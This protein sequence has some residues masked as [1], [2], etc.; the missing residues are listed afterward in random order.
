MGY[1]PPMPP[2]GYPPPM[3]WG[4]PP[5]M[6]YPPMVN[7]R[8]PEHGYRSQSRSRSRSGG[9]KGRG[10]PRGG[11]QRSRERGRGKSG[12]F[13]AFHAQNVPKGVDN[14]ARAATNASDGPKTTAML[15]NIPNKYMQSALLE[16]IDAEGFSGQYDFLYLPMD[17]HNKTNVGYA[18]VNFIQSSDLDRF[19]SQF[20][21]R[22]F[23]KYPS[24]KI[25]M[26]SPAHVNGL[27]ANVRQLSKKAVAQFRDPEYQPIV[28]RDG[29]RIPFNT[30]LRELEKGSL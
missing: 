1:P 24:Q 30:A 8:H 13:K 5:P 2:M 14:E 7:G 29:K 9:G 27:E 3:A 19:C 21:D 22:K 12:N 23:L 20:A 16:E 28:F 25:A 15:R 4:Y 6:P 17:S 11:R 18:F 10:R 26:C